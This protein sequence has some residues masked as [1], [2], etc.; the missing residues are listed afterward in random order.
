MT[1][2][3]LIRTIATKTSTSPRAVDKVLDA[4]RDAVHELEV[5][6]SIT[7]PKLGTFHAKMRSPRKIT[8][9]QGT[10][11]DVPARRAVTFRQAKPKVEAE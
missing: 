6:S 4:L 9:L 5:G 2:E 1:Y 7:L 11:V 8:T 3:L 10:V